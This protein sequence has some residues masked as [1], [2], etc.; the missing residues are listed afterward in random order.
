MDP[1]VARQSMI[2]KANQVIAAENVT[3]TE[4]DLIAVG[5]AEAVHDLD[6]WLRQGGFLPDAWLPRDFERSPQQ[7][8]RQAVPLAAKPSK[9]VDDERPRRD[10]GPCGHVIEEARFD[11]QPDLVCTL[12]RGHEGDHS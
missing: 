4:A 10:P 7:G 1:D 6:E 9:E 11:S 2:D 12:D 3:G 5:L 8:R